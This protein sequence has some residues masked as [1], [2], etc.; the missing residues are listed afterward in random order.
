MSECESDYSDAESASAT[1][2]ESIV[3]SSS[4][5]VWNFVDLCNVSVSLSVCSLNHHFIQSIFLYSE[6]Y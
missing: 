2:E 4:I 6:Y 5:D 3:D 1:S